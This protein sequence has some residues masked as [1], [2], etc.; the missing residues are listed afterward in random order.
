[1]PGLSRARL[2]AYSATAISVDMVVVPITAVLPA[3]YAK[4]TKATLAAIG[5]WLVVTR[6]FDAVSDQAIGYWSDRTGGRFGPRKPWILAG[7]AVT[8]LSVVFLFRP[9]ADTTVAYFGIWALVFYLGYTMMNIPYIAWGAELSGDYRERSRIVTYRTVA[10]SFGGVLFLA[11]PLLLPFETT[12]MN[13]QVLSAVAWGTLILVPVTVAITCFGVPS[14]PPL[15]GPPRTP[16]LLVL[17]SVLKNRPF[18][19]YL[20]VF[21]LG[22]I[23]L[24]FYATLLLMFLDSYLGIGAK[25]SHIMAAT[26][27]V[28]WLATPLWLQVTNRW[29]K[30]RPWAWSLIAGSLGLMLFVFVEPGPGAFWPALIISCLCGALGACGAVAPASILADIVEYDRLKSGEDRA[31]NYFAFHL[32]VVKLAVAVS[33]GFAFLMLDWFG[34]DPQATVHDATARLGM[35]LAFVFIPNLLQIV[36]VF[37]VWNFPIDE[38]AQRIVRRRL[39]QRDARLARRAAAQTAM[40]PGL[41]PDGKVTEVAT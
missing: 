20:F 6:I 32:M 10:G 4:N 12:E 27:V 31:G 14:A 7:G 5:V 19:R 1:M 18:R 17:R 13:A 26:A 3:F 35:L 33:G 40:V 23:Q 28:S 22:A 29:G 16:M 24:G 9:T 41:T 36:S 25:F 21:I 11:A 8:M 39:E 38:R 2:L 34:F 37:A 15:L 30:H